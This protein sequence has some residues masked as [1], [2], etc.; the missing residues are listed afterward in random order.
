MLEM[1]PPVA[2]KKIH[3]WIRTRH[4]I[5]SKNFLIFE[6]FDYSAVE[7][8]EESIVSLGGELISVDALKKVWRGKHRQVI[9][10]QAKGTLNKPNHPIQQYW[11]KNG[12]LYTRFDEHY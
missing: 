1:L 8:F 11:Y 10:Y 7:R 6:T 12:S 3:T 2:I 4:L 5:C 9:L